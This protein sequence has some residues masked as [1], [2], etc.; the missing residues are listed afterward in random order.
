[1]EFSGPFDKTG[2]SRAII[3]SAP[4]PIWVSDSESGGIYFNKAW[5]DFTG[6]TMHD[7]LG[8]GW[9]AGVHPEDRA[10]LDA[11]AKATQ[12]RQPFWTEFRLR[13]HD[14]VYR[15]VLDSASPRFAPDGGFLGYMGSCIDITDR[16]EAEADLRKSEERL[17]VAVQHSPVVLYHCNRDLR[18]TWIANPPPLWPSERL[19]GRRDDELLPPHHAA[20]LIAFK[21]RV[22][23]SGI[24]AREEVSV[25]ASG[26]FQTWDITAEPLVDEKNKI[27]GLTVA[28]LDVTAG[29]TAEERQ[30]LLTAELDHRVRNTLAAIQSLVTLSARSGQ[31]KEE[32]TLALQGR[33]D[34]YTRIYGFLAS[35]QWQCVNLHQLTAAVTR[36]FGNSIAS[37]FHV[38]GENF[39]LDPSAAISLNLILHE[40]ATNAVRYGAAS[41]LN[42]RVSLTWEI[43]DGHF[44]MVWRES[45]GPAISAQIR[46]G[47]GTRLIRQLLAKD[48]RATF[49]LE[50][51]TEGALLTASI[52]LKRLKVD[53][54]SG[55]FL[56]MRPKPPGQA[57]VD[58]PIGGLAKTR[59]L[60]VEDDPLIGLEFQTALLD[61]G[62]E[63]VGPMPDLHHSLTAIMGE[64]CRFDAAILDVNLRG[65]S[66]L[67]LAQLLFERGVPYIFV[68][69]YD[70]E[71]AL[72]VELR[73]AP[74]LQKPVT[75]TQLLAAIQTLIGTVGP[76]KTNG[77]GE[78]Q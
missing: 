35:M 78:L 45:D 25:T 57:L 60:L 55:D 24:G 13:R 39:L 2:Q 43:R 3:D 6:R 15:W 10:E 31:S 64:G 18:Y 22:L 38:D 8:E 41:V 73:R 65:E 30:R 49:Q 27:V 9:I 23:D 40:L 77:V 59:V 17:R 71:T 28:A 76:R 58:N 44:I 51:P 12:M 7:E 52:P 20:D 75:G 67:P 16:K 36:I 47:F 48:L 56:D 63:T 34:A 54:R 66:T 32:Y 37:R 19:L 1:M 68:S 4:V 33:I 46:P 29:K 62:V 69:G 21:Q 53:N 14:G 70:L 74:K 61:A 26:V 42:G 5:L 72:P 50:Y 11:G